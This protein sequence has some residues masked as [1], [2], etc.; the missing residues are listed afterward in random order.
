MSKK[1]LLD[2][3][4]LF[5]CVLLSGS[6]AGQN[7]T[8]NEKKY[9]PDLTVLEQQVQTCDTL[10]YGSFKVDS[11][12]FQQ[13]LMVQKK[14]IDHYLLLEQQFPQRGYAQ[15]AFYYLE[16]MKGWQLFQIFRNI[17]CVDSSRWQQKQALLRQQKLVH[18]IINLE[19][20]LAQ[21]NDEAN[22]V[23]NSQMHELRRS[24]SVLQD[25]VRKFDP[26]FYSFF[27]LQAPMALSALQKDCLEEK[28]IMLNFYAQED[29][30][31]VFCVTRDS[32]RVVQW[33]CPTRALKKEMMALL[34]PFYDKTD[35]LNLE[36]DDHLAHD[37]YRQLF[38]PLEGIT[39]HY[40]IILIM[41][42]DFLI[43]F[44]F[45]LLVADTTLSG[46]LNGNQRYQRFQQQQFL[47][48]KYA[49][50]YNYSTAALS[51]EFEKFRF[52]RKIGHRLLTM[53]EPIITSS[54]NY[55]SNEADELYF[56]LYISNYVSDE[57]KR[58]A[59]LLWRHTIL[60]RERTTKTNLMQQGGA[61]R[62]LYLALPGILN[63]GVPINSALLFTQE[64]ADSIALSCW[65]TPGEI[66][67]ARFSADLLTLSGTQLMSLS[68]SGNPGAVVLP[69]SFLYGGVKSVLFSLWRIN[70]ISTSEFMSKFY[71]ELKYKRQ[72]NAQALQAAKVA[73]MKDDFVY[74]GSKISRAQPYFWAPYLLIGHPKI[75]SPYNTRIP[76]WGV[77]VLVYVCV[78]LV[79]L[80]I[81]RK[82]MPKRRR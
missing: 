61:Y 59:R 63:N 76:V 78:I 67:K 15:K 3:I 39:H 64:Y 5:L 60:K 80:T 4:I 8:D 22:D 31:T 52:D 47:V 37:L 38:L 62:Y 25:S 34:T 30:M 79:A 2:K 36:F 6:G 51:P 72:T 27:L 12:I 48:H 14:L 46:P 43:G 11:A 20:K 13:G 65:L 35:L 53:S 45:E 42:D 77:I 49:F 10:F 55:S 56:Q 40:K 23:L 66:M 28:E 68:R 50:C 69:Q 41:P 81:T 57:V 17:V 19:M 74:F 44:P 73:S 21:S 16:K 18:S 29:Q 75:R 82:T 1:R 24:L 71:W 32:F 70:S 7:L 58:V 26:D 9:P 54:S 33:P